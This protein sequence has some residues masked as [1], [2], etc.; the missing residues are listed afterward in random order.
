MFIR[1][2][3]QAILNFFAGFKLFSSPV[4]GIAAVI[5]AVIVIAL[6][7]HVIRCLNASEYDFACSHC[8]KR[9]FTKWYKLVP[10]YTGHPLAEF[11]P[12]DQILYRHTARLRCPACEK[13]TICY[14]PDFYPDDFKPPSIWSG[15]KK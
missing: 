15:K 2:V 5:G 9:F 6:I 14:M 1:Y 13:K 3:L 8:G 12:V 7:A 11:W 4:I 10:T